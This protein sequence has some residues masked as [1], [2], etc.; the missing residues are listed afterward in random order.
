MVNMFQPYFDLKEIIE[1]GHQHSLFIPNIW[2]VC[3]ETFWMHNDSPPYMNDKMVVITIALT[4][5]SKRNPIPSSIFLVKG[6][7]GSDWFVTLGN[8]EK[9]SSHSTLH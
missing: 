9:Y 4:L 2:T 7:T 1:T 8:K 6:L 3:A 5:W